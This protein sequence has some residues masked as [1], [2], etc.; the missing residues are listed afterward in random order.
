MNAGIRPIRKID[1]RSS[2]AGMLKNGHAFITVK[3]HVNDKPLRFYGEPGDV[4]RAGEN[5]GTEANILL[6]IVSLFLV[7]N[8]LIM[9][10]VRQM[11][12]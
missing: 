7:N 1:L 4:L 10:L 11:S 2:E 8:N 6:K 5:D 3:R 12:K 9:V